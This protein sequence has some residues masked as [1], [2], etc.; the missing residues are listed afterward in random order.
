MQDYRQEWTL[1]FHTIIIYYTFQ[2][3]LYLKF[4]TDFFKYLNLTYFTYLDTFFILCTFYFKR[5][6]INK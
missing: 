4:C 5:K 3:Q 1:L 6:K 2:M